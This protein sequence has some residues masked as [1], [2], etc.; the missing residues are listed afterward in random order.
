MG[1]ANN[2]IAPTVTIG[3]G[4]WGNNSISE[5]LQ[6]YHLMNVTRVSTELPDPIIHAEE[7]WDVYEMRSEW[8]QKV[9]Y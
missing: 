3:C 4:S 8:G 7:D 1:S 9:R 6:Y 5:N 2:A